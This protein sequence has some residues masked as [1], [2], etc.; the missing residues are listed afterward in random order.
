MA[1]YIT[2]DI[3]DQDIKNMLRVMRSAGRDLRR[4]MG[5]EIRHVAKPV[6]DDMKDTI[7]A[8]PLPV[9]S[10]YGVN[11][12][13][14]PSGAGGISGRIAAATKISITGRGVRIRVA[15][16]ALGNA[17]NLPGYIDA[18]VTWRHPVMGNRRAWVGQRAA[19]DGWFTKTGLKHHPQIKREVT[20]ILMRY[21]AQMAARL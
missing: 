20:E 12:Y 3:R 10:G 8:M 18:G 15:T 19:R 5:K 1:G 2:I 17:S 9:V 13:N 6:L 7:E 14:G 4:D 16:G 21:A 11:A